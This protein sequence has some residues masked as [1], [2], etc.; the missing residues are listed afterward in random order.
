MSFEISYV[1]APAAMAY[2]PKVGLEKVENGWIIRR[3]K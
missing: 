1:E 3:T 2:Y